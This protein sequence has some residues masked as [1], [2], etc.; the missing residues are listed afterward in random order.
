MTK[1]F[2][3]SYLQIGL[4]AINTILLAKGYVIGIFLASF[5]ISLLWC[6]NVT[7]ISV[8]S[9][10]QKLVYSFGAGFGAISG[11]YLLNFIGVV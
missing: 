6:Y 8:G 5:S 4:V 9:L 11:F 10:K 2:L 7:K 1:I 3:T